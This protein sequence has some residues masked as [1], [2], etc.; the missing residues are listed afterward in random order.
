MLEEN[1]KK[2]S[3]NGLTMVALVV[4]V[5]VLAILT[6]VIVTSTFGDEGL[7]DEAETAMLEQKRK[8]SIEKIAREIQ[9]V[10]LK[11]EINGQYTFSVADDVIPILQTHGTYDN[12]TLK[13]I[14]SEGA[15]IYL[16]EIMQI[17]MLEY[18]TITYEEDT[19]TITS[20]L[21]TNGYVIEYT[22]NGG[23]VWNTYT[24][25]VEIEEGNGI[26]TRIKNSDNKVV[27]NTVKVKE[28]TMQSEDTTP[29]I[30]RITPNTVSARSADITIFVTEYGQ[31]AND[32][33]Y[34]YYLSTSPDGQIGGAWVPYTPGEKFTIG[35][36]L[37]G[38]YYIHVKEVSD[39]AGNVSDVKVSGA[40]SFNENVDRTPPV[41]FTPTITKLN[42]SSI[43]IQASTTDEGSGI[44]H[45]TYS[46]E[47]Y[48]VEGKENK[49]TSPVTVSKLNLAQNSYTIIVRAYDKEGNAQEARKLISGPTDGSFCQERG[50]NSPLLADGMVAV[51]WN[52]T[53]E[54][55][56]ANPN[57][58][59]NFDYDSWYNYEQQ[60]AA[61]TNGGTS[62]WANAKTADG[63]YWVWVPRYAYSITSGYHGQGLTYVDNVTTEAG[64]IEIEFLQGKT[65][66]GAIA[67]RNYAEAAGARNWNVHPAF[68]YDGTSTTGTQLAGIWVAKYE[69][70]ME[71]SGAATETSDESIGNKSVVDN[72]NIKA[73]SKP[74][75]TAWRYINRN[76]IFI[77]ALNYDTTSVSNANLDSHLMKN[78]EWGA[79]AYLAHSKYGR[80]A[81]EI[82][83]NAN[84]SFYTAGGTV[85]TA[86][87]NVLQSTTGN[88]YGI[89]DISGCSW[90]HTAAYMTGASATATPGSNGASL[91]NA[92]NKYKDV[93][94]APD[95]TSDYSERNDV[96][97]YGDGIWETSSA[98]YTNESGTNNAGWYADWSNFVESAY[99]FFYRGGFCSTSTSP[100]AF[101]FARSTGNSNESHSWRVVLWGEKEKP[102][103]LP[104]W[105]STSTSLNVTT[106][107]AQEIIGN[108]KYYAPIPLGFS[109]VAGTI[110][111]GLVIQ[112]ASAN[113]FVWVPVND[114]YTM[115]GD[116]SGEGTFN[117]YQTSSPY[118]YDI[119]YLSN[120]TTTALAY[121]QAS[122]NGHSGTITGAGTYSEPY[123]GAGSWETTEYQAMVTSVLK[124]G[125]FYVGRYETGGSAS[126]PV[127]KSGV[128]PITNI[129]WNS[130][131][132]MTA[133]PTSGTATYVARNMYPSTSTTYG[134]VSTLIYGIQ[135]DSIMC[136]ASC[137]NA[138]TPTKGSVGNTGSVSTDCYKNIYDL[139]GNVYEWSMEAEGTSIRVSRGGY[140]NYVYAVSTRGSPPVDNYSYVGFRAAL[141]VK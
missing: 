45:Y 7:I 99:P 51:Y 135:W 37:E 70:S 16:S 33:V 20:P 65:N 116:I 6:G 73:V 138:T 30:V 49:F 18:A 111:T 95:S 104:E 97:V 139:A 40:L 91:I 39:I 21:T 83:I 80:N 129:Q 28:G 131:D 63:S 120:N 68:Y 109:V 26:Y 107:Y 103:A 125:G 62:K 56:S 84:S 140:Y 112:D 53:T 69:M 3:K 61:T 50:V 43:Q 71:T 98:C 92:A 59:T 42:T 136:W 41:A 31:L 47:T 123:S 25:P 52:G 121:W 114:S 13:L 108:T 102:A 67:T 122:A 86:H 34:E 15:E 19:L 78:S 22:P 57:T 9:T 115:K 10:Q 32:N 106:P 94:D 77:N 133:E 24:A 81:T 27:S 38:T 113:Q 130:T 127:V 101:A 89:F 36:D 72:T 93:Y 75:V 66:I 23:S 126:A 29:P 4:T 105:I 137:Y 8:A 117:N 14:T 128:T 58:D 90:E 54:V 76:N 134:V 141:Y 85:A 110:S 17:P 11:K 87:T 132:T 1:L 96:R 12:A 119:P 5:V 44:S 74:G 82:T 48:G 124:Y 46:I 100:G 35:E 118:N 79:V 2:N 60:T 88:C 55:T 64:T